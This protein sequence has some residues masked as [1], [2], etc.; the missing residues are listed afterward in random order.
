MISQDIYMYEIVG[1]QNQQFVI[2]IYQRNYEWGKDQCNQLLKDII[3]SGKTEKEHFLG[4]LVH[5]DLPSTWDGD[6]KMNF[7]QIIDGQQRLTTLLLIYL[8]VYQVAKRMQNKLI[9]DPLIAYLRNEYVG[10]IRYRLRLKTSKNNEQD[11]NDLLNE[12]T[13]PL[14]RKTSKIITNFEFFTSEITPEN[15]RTINRGLQK[16]KCVVVQLAENE[17][18]QR[19]FESLNSTGLDLNQADLIRNY[20]LMDLDLKKQEEFYT[21]YWE[22][23]ERNAQPKQNSSKED[24]LSHF[25]RDYMIL[26]NVG[27][28]KKTS[29]YNDFKLY[30]ETQTNTNVFSKISVLETTLN[31]MKELAKHYNKLLNTDEEPDR[32]IRQHLIYIKQL[33]IN[34]SH[35]FL[36]Q[37]YYDYDKKQIITKEEFINILELIQSYVVRRLIIG[38]GTNALGKVFYS[39]YNKIDTNNYFYSIQKILCTQIRTARFP[40]NQEVAEV[41]KT[42]DIY[43]MDGKNNRY[44]LERIENYNNNEYVEVAENNNIT[45]EHIFPRNPAPSWKKEFGE[46]EYQEIMDIYLHTLGNLTL[47]GKNN[48]LSNKAFKEKKDIYKNSSLWLNKLLIKL[49]K[50]GISEIKKRSKSIEKRFFYIW[51]YPNILLPEDEE[52]YSES[53]IFDAQ[54]PTN[55]SLDYAIFM[56]EKIPSPS[57]VSLYLK[58]IKELYDLDASLLLTLADK[59]NIS[60][61]TANLKA[62]SRL[63]HL[64]Y[65]DKHGSASDLFRR[66]KLCL[67]TFNIQDELIIKY[68][69]SK[70][71][72][73]TTEINLFD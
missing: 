12:N 25:I 62:P 68:I 70:T 23:I 11:F 40:K 29:V 50:W 59:I 35:P 5:S 51:T 65:V 44:L 52:I 34:V 13:L 57:Y 43:N 73:A 64:Y 20:I 9:A 46:K 48:E 27:K 14:Q 58:I 21:V 30:I 39:L 56:D 10:D 7:I 18:P 63:G 72:L 71:P 15:Y 41:L 60:D 3:Q 31:E 16:L 69:N 22:D 36:M 32:K 2:P 49:D 4:I 19:I 28:K 47:T 33:T 6:T 61:T 55:L 54:D 37:V 66:I 26:K 1:K 17:N 45:I 38:L 53:S 67:N 8:V 24:Y 42:K